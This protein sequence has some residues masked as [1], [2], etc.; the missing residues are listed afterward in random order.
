MDLYSGTRPPEHGPVFDLRISVGAECFEHDW[1]PSTA[2]VQTARR[3]KRRRTYNFQSWQIELTEVLTTYLPADNS[4][5]TKERKEQTFEVEIELDSGGHSMLERNLDALIK[6][7]RGHKLW[8][9]LS[10][11]MFTARDLAVLAAEI[12]P[13]PLPPRLGTPLP[14]PAAEPP[15]KKAFANKYGVDFI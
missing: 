1:F 3:E 7:S 15:S 8:Q 6:G 14:V 5:T 13:L 9:L 4:G 11:F 12:E 2:H 10:D